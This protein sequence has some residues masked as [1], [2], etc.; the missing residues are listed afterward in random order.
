MSTVIEICDDLN[1]HPKYSPGSNNPPQFDQFEEI[2]EEEVL[3]MIYSMEAK[4]CGS[5]PVPSLV[6]KDL[7]PYIIKDITT[8]VNVS[9]REGVFAN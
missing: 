5:D 1:N 7:A 9:L 8:I 2:T 4:T 6:L 3:I